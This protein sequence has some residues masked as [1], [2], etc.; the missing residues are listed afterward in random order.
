[1]V[2]TSLCVQHRQVQWFCELRG[3]VHAKRVRDERV[4]LGQGRC[5][6]PETKVGTGARAC[7]GEG[8]KVHCWTWP[9]LSSLPSQVVLLPCPCSTLFQTHWAPSH[10]SLVHWLAPKLAIVFSLNDKPSAASTA[11]TPKARR[12]QVKCRPE[13]SFDHLQPGTQPAQLLCCCIT[14]HA[15]PSA[16]LTFLRRR[17]AACWLTACPCRRTT[18]CWSSAT[19]SMCWMRAGP[20]ASRSAPTASPHYAP[21]L[22]RSQVSVAYG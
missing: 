15:M 9:A 1:M 22:A 11:S 2:S 7:S 8:A 17:P 5:C 21:Y 4:Q 14:L 16:G 19:A 12:L 18:T 6:W 3:A 13:L 10:G 20:W